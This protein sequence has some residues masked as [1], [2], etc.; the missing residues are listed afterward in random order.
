VSRRKKTNR[1]QPVND[2]HER[3][4][5]LLFVLKSYYMRETRVRFY[6]RLYIQ[7]R[8]IFLSFFFK[9]NY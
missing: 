1:F 9:N 4:R 3:I 5:I 6:L 7:G 8:R 2:K